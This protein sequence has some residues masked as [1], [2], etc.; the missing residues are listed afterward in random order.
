[1]KRAALIAPSLAGA[2]AFSLLSL[3]SGCAGGSVG[4]TGHGA[5]GVKGGTSP[6]ADRAVA[7]EAPAGASTGPTVSFAA[8]GLTRIQPSTPVSPA[9]AQATPELT[10]YPSAA[11]K[12]GAASDTVYS[13]AGTGISGSTPY[14]EVYTVVYV[15]GSGIAD[16]CDHSVGTPEYRIPLAPN[17]TFHILDSTMRPDKTT[18]FAGFRT[19][20]AGPDGKYDGSYALFQITLDDKD[21]ATGFTAVYTA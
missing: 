20:A 8:S 11:V 12:T 19:Y 3:L 2:A 14:V 18:D 5:A 7:A 6:T 17:A 9:L 4:G 13:I 10:L 21:R 15:C 16:D 1:M